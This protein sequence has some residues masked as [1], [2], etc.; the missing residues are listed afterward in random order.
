MIFA[1]LQGSSSPANRPQC[2]PENCKENQNIGDAAQKKT[3][4]LL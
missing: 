2:V 4:N 1:A 3:A